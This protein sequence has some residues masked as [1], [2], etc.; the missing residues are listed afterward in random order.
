MR[1]D[2]IA[3]TIIT[4]LV[5]FYLLLNLP[6]WQR[7]WHTSICAPGSFVDTQPSFAAFATSFPCALA[8]ILAF[9]T[10][11]L[12][13][14]GP[15]PGPEAPTQRFN[16]TLLTRATLTALAA[17]LS[18]AALLL[19]LTAPSSLC[20]DATG[21]RLRPARFTPTATY[22]WN[23]VKRI[24]VTCRTGKYGEHVIAIMEL[25]DGKTI[26][27]DAAA[28]LPNI[29]TIG[30]ALQGADYVYDA[31]GAQAGNCSNRTKIMLAT[32]PGT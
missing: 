28:Y 15:A 19:W 23:Q 10:I 8:L 5:G 16:N 9:A 29:K 26:S 31:T 13:P 11:A 30:T 21:I 7:A 25:H 32:W 24:E 22:R 17:T 18:I 20:M 3:A 6:G 14:T 12:W 4:A 2:K 27:V 1:A